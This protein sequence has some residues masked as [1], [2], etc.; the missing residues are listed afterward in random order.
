MRRWELL[1]PCA[2][3]SYKNTENNANHRHPEGHRQPLKKHMPII[4]IVEYG[5]IDAVRFI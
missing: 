2:N 1:Q 4:S 3:N 5:K